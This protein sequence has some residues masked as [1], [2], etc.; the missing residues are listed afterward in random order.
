MHDLLLDEVDFEFDSKQVTDR[1]QASMED[2]S[3]LVL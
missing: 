3:N 2:A 1:F